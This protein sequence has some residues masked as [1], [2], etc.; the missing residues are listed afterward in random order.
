MSFTNSLESVKQVIVDKG[1]TIARIAIG[2]FVMVKIATLITSLA[3]VIFFAGKAYQFL[4]E[5]GAF[6]GFSAVLKQLV[7]DNAKPIAIAT[8]I[9][10]A[11]VVMPIGG[12][13]LL[14]RNFSSI[15]V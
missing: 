15:P 11:L 6:N 1:P 10:T 5:S 7:V 13:Y 9:A 2:A 8:T 12:A 3:I 4:K 14:Y